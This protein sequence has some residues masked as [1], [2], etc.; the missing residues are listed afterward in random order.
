VAQKVGMKWALAFFESHTPQSMTRLL[1]FFCTLAAC[2]IAIRHPSQW[3]S[4]TALIGGG[5]VSLMARSKPK[6]GA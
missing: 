6:S 1:A 2:Y 5:A 4:I 3:Q